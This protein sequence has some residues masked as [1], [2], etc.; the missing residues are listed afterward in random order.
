[1][2]LIRLLFF[3]LFLLFVRGNSWGQVLRS[4]KK[5]DVKNEVMDSIS[6]KVK[7]I[8]LDTIIVFKT[9][10]IGRLHKL[11]NTFSYKLEFNKHNFL[12]YYIQDSLKTVFTLKGNLKLIDADTSN[13][14]SKSFFYPTYREINFTYS[15]DISD[16]NIEYISVS[17]NSFL[18]KMVLTLFLF[19]EDE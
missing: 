17:K 9:A 14:Y 15:C 2:Y 10:D 8:Q 19:K 13:V 6:Y 3:I 16:L 5:E 1:M 7:L 11:N 4:K 18:K 12:I